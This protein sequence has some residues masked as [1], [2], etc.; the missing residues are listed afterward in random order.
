M[1]SSRAGIPL[2]RGSSVMPR[3]GDRSPDLGFGRAR[4]RERDARHP[5]AHPARREGRAL[6]D[7]SPPQG[8]QPGRHFADGV[9]DPRRE[10]ADRRRLQDRARHHRAQ[11]RRASARASEERFRN[12]ANTV[13]DIVWTAD[14]DGAITFVNDRWFGICG[15]TR[16]RMLGR[17]GAGAAS[18]RPRALHRE[19]T[20]RCDRGPSMRSRCAIDGTMVSI[21]GF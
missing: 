15:V 14:P 7:G 2:R 9:A 11:A 4:S 3:G 20:R 16:R 19:W 8:R 21:G 13:P 10:R 6:R 17:A 1:A 12:L 18:R 5:G